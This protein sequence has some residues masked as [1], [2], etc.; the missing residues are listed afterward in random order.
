MNKPKYLQIAEQLIE[1][2]NT[3]VLPAGSILPTEGELQERFDVS[4]VTIRKSMKVLVDMDLLFRKRGS[5]TY[6]KAPKAQHNAFQ[7]S[8]FVEEVS[9]QG[10]KP[11]S[12]IIT[13]ELIKSN[14]LIADKLGLS[15]GDEVYSV[16]RL[17]LIDDEPEILE[18]TFLPVSMFPDLSLSAMRS[19]KYEYIEKTKGLKIKLASQS[20]KAEILT[21]PIAKEL[22]VDEGY[23]VIRVDSVGELDDGRVFEYTIHYF[24]GHQYSFDYIA[25]REPK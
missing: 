19:S 7:L 17:R 21:K 9:E 25:Y 5:G 15:E 16:R 8:G 18:H 3:G 12:K 2:I 22:N 13:F 4:R 11:G 20:A 6:V 23:P 10:K 1:Q 24:R 14:A